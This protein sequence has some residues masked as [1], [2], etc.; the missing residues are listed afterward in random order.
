MRFIER[1]FAPPGGATSVSS[2]SACQCI[3]NNCSKGTRLDTSM[4]LIPVLFRLCKGGL[5][6]RQGSGQTACKPG[7][8]R[9][10]KG[11]TAI[12]L[13][14]ALRC[15]SCDQPGRRVGNVPGGLHRPPPLFG[16]APGGVCRAARVAVGAVRSCRPVSPLPGAPAGGP[17]GLFSVALSLGSPPPAVSRHRVPVEP[18]LSSGGG[19][20]ERAPAAV[21]PSGQGEMWHSLGRV[22][23][24]GE[25]AADWFLAEDGARSRRGVRSNET[26]TYS[27]EIEN[28]CDR[29]RRCRSVAPPLLTSAAAPPLLCLGGT[30]RI[31]GGRPQRRTPHSRLRRERR[32]LW[33]RPHPTA[34]RPGGRSGR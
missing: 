23:Q 16:L 21:R 15:A 29:A 2:S 20:F 8:V 11:G 27:L 28:D 31:S 9:P 3:L 18:G 7:S 14:R 10:G 32:R 19:L 34:A 12:P 5:G 13:G 26:I 1:I 6:T 17:G 4:T 22:N 30:G 25:E 33:V 24:P